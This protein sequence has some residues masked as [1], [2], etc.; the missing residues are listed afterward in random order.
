MTPEEI[1]RI[2]REACEQLIN[3]FEAGTSYLTL[4]PADAA[5]M[6]H[7]VNREYPPPAPR[8]EPAL[9]RLAGLVRALAHDTW[10]WKDTRVDDANELLL[11]VQSDAEGMVEEEGDSQRCKAPPSDDPPA[12]GT[13]VLPNQIK[14]MSGGSATATIPGLPF[15]TPAPAPEEARAWWLNTL[16]Q[17]V[18]SSE[19]LALQATMRGDVIPVVPRAALDAMREERDQL[20]RACDEM[21]PAE[22]RLDLEHEVETLRAQL[23][24]AERELGDLR[25]ANSLLH[26]SLDEALSTCR[27]LC[28]GDPLSEERA[29]FV[30]VNDEGDTLIAADTPSEVLRQVVKLWDAQSDRV[31]AAERELAGVRKV[32]AW[33][34]EVPC[35]RIFVRSGGAFWLSEYSDIEETYQ[36]IASADSLAALGHA[37]SPD[38]DTQEGENVR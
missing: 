32:E 38:H 7:Y 17:K 12:G 1:A 37:L 28:P 35:R 33:V 11:D 13:Q 24:A 9:V 34:E 19:S 30:L 4:K 20:Q 21:F 10:D 31:E 5:R 27:T 3:E 18:Y 8:K 26:Q 6:R 22:M 14:P 2:K 29:A 15:N 25:T 23:A 16:S 36:L